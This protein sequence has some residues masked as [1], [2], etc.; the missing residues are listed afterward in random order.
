MEENASKAETLEE[1]TFYLL[2]CRY[3]VVVTF[4]GFFYSSYLKGTVSDV[5]HPK[6]SLIHSLTCETPRVRCMTDRPFNG[7][8]VS[9]D[10]K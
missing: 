8:S 4:L 3:K 9:A 10:D 5:F 2:T 6:V 7:V 1:I